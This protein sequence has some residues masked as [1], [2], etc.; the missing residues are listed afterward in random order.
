MCALTKRIFHK[1]AVHVLY[2]LPP[3]VAGRGFNYAKQEQQQQQQQQQL[4]TT[5][6]TRKKRW[7]SIYTLGRVV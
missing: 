1:R 7:S 3:P 2:H 4:T 6:T 5:T